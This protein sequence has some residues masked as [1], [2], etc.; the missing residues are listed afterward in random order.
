MTK[1]DECREL[2]RF[3]IDCDVTS[4]E[5]TQTWWVDAYSED[6][7]LEKFKTDG[8]EIYAEE[9]GVM[10]CGKPYIVGETELDDY[11]DFQPDSRVS[12]SAKSDTQTDLS[13]MGET[14]GADDLVLVPRDLIGAAC[15]AIDKKRDAPK[16]LERLRRYTFGDLSQAMC[17]D[18]APM[19][20][21]E[22]RQMVGAMHHYTAENIAAMVAELKRLEDP[23]QSTQADFDNKDWRTKCGILWRVIA[24]LASDVPLTPQAA[25][26]CEPVY[27]DNHTPEPWRLGHQG[28]ERG[29]ILATLPDGGPFV[30]ADTNWNF[31]ES[32]QADARR[33]VACVNALQGL[34]N[35]ALAGGWTYSGIDSYLIALEKKYKD[36]DQQ[37]AAQPPAADS[38]LMEADRL[39]FV[40]KEEASIT[41]ME[42]PDGTYK[43]TL[44]GRSFVNSGWHD[45][46]RAAID[47]AIAAQSA[48]QD[49]GGEDAE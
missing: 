7:A 34:S 48:K 9:I 33:I 8:G 45:S 22:G 42:R 30:V 15:S 10:D 37:L 21:D 6:E 18:Y 46:A 16:L 25:E 24:G 14:Q 44:G 27:A 2:K 5:G 23:E 28:M 47:A 20:D 31:P 43:Y 40:L 35:D 41:V 12:H 1:N 19:L 32:A 38:A 49:G 36:M 29:K 11:G 3:L 13:I 39:D 4:V 17:D 26:K